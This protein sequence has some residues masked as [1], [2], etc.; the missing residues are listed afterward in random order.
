MLIAIHNFV[1]GLL[2]VLSERTDYH[3]QR[4]NWLTKWRLKP[5]IPSLPP[6]AR[7]RSVPGLLLTGR[8]RR[9]LDDDEARID[10]AVDQC[11]RWRSGQTPRDRGGHRHTRSFPLLR[12]SYE[13]GEYPQRFPLA[14]D[15][16]R[17]LVRIQEDEFGGIYEYCGVGARPT[18]MCGCCRM[19]SACD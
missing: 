14:G 9:R 13:A 19:A 15:V 4:A 7:A 8:G 17:P 11:E 1:R 2:P 16:L 3:A 18:D 12:T 6:A 10:G 5:Q